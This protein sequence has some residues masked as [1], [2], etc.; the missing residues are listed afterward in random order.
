MFCLILKY[1]N[2][3]IHFTIR[4][5]EYLLYNNTKIYTFK[6]Q[7]NTKINLL[8]DSVTAKAYKIIH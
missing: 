5:I 8:Y 2:I 7:Y 6:L 3:A 1:N 4:I